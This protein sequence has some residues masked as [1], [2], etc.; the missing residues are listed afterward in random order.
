LIGTIT[1]LLAKSADFP[2]LESQRTDFDRLL[3]PIKE[4][5]LE[6]STRA[7]QGVVETYDVFIP[8]YNSYITEYNKLNGPTLVGSMEALVQEAD[9]QHVEE[10]EEEE[11]PKADERVS[12][13][14]PAPTEDS[15][16]VDNTQEDEDDFVDNMQEDEEEEQAPAPAETTRGKRKAQPT[17]FYTPGFTTTSTDSHSEEVDEQERPAKHAKHSH[18]SCSVYALPCSLETHSA[19]V[20][21]LRLC[22]WPSPSRR[23]HAACTPCPLR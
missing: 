8:K 20:C 3:Q 6:M 22:E 4:A 7:I 15:D 11:E 14:A 21:V 10:S 13:Q 16:F 12:P 1:Y 5:G 18:V 2:A 19:C 23:K 9:A 17:K